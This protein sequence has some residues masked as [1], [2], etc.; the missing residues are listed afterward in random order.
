MKLT[1]EWSRFSE[2]AN[3]E[4]VRKQKRKLRSAVSAR[5]WGKA[6]TFIPQGPQSSGR[7][8]VP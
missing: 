6:T 7:V 5:V 8:C 4:L 3:S 2:E 1:E